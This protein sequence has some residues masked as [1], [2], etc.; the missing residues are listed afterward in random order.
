MIK[1]K[2]ANL[3]SFANIAHHYI[4]LNCPARPEMGHQEEKR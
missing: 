1:R 3:Q 4:Q 2:L